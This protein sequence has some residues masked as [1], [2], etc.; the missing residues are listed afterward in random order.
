MKAA[1]IKGR[2]NINPLMSLLLLDI[3][4]IHQSI[5]AVVEV[6]QR[7]DITI[8]VVITAKADTITEIITKKE[9]DH[10]QMKAQFIVDQDVII[11]H[12]KATKDIPRDIIP[13]EDITSR[14][15][16]KVIAVILL[17]HHKAV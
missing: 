13:R 16:Q 6:D 10:H 17:H 12:L 15:D 4:I 3:T 14:I 2:I 8:E 7:A 11:D 9:E 5:I 1:D